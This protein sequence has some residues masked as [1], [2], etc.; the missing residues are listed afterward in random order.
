MSR[1]ADAL[2]EI[3]F[4]GNAPGRRAK[5]AILTAIGEIWEFEETEGCG[6]VLAY[7]GESSLYG[8]RT[9]EDLAGEIA[10]AVWAAQSRPC[11]ISVTVWDLEC[12]PS[13]SFRYDRTSRRRWKR[14][15]A[16]KE[17]SENWTRTTGREL[18]TA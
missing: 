3:K 18:A 6:A 4:R 12:P 1:Y 13:E 17:C 11:E 8:G 7:R 16:L 2:L 5:A 15:G 14:T 9:A 10:A